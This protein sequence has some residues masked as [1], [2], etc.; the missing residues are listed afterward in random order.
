MNNF[1]KSMVFVA[2]HEW[3]NRADGGYTNDPV[4]PGGET[5][6]G[7]SKRAHPGID[8]KGLTLPQ[9][10]H[11]YRAEYWDANNLDSVAY[12]YSC[13]CL[14]SFIQHGHKTTTRMMEDSGGDLR[15]FFGSRRE[16]Y[17]G[18]IAKKPEEVKYKNGWMARINDLSKFCDIALNHP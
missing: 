8:I 10:L 6:F 11:I 16:Y 7:I 13:A 9:A 15:I 4:D 2:L 12:P 5:K 3:S 18:I 1:E 17:L 14:D